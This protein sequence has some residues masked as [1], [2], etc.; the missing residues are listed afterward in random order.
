MNHKSVKRKTLSIFLSLCMVLT[1]LP[2]GLLPALAAEDT[3]VTLTSGHKT[4]YDQ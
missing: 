4:Q 3:F 1:V 2:L